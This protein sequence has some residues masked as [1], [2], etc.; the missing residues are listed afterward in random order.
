MLKINITL[1]DNQKLYF[2]SDLHLGHRNVI[3]FCDRP[4]ENEKQMNQC[5]IDNWNSTITN[6]DIVFIL[7]D[8]VW[9]NDSHAIKRLFEKLN[10]Q[11][12]YVIP[13]NH[14]Q[15]KSY[16]RVDDPRIKLVN[17]ICTLYVST[18][19]NRY[20][21]NIIEIVC[22]HY[23]LMTWAHRELGA[24]NLFGHIHSGWLRS[25]EAFDQML[26]LWK[27]QQYDVGVD[28]NNYHPVSLDDILTELNK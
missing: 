12:I 21:K 28:N 10:G 16:H 20:T 25:I 24:I 19:N 5:L 7:G 2:T 14:D 26:P 13:G 1:K 9:F 8:L 15:M 17:D 11:E 23:P 22:C 18:E 27:G 3:R 6:N 4:Y